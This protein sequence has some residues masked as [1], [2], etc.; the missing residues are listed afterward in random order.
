MEAAV[1]EQVGF[2]FEAWALGVGD[3]QEEQTHFLIPGFLVE[4][5]ITM[6]YGKEKQGKSWL[7]YGI[8][9]WL[10]EHERIQKVYYVDQDNPKRQLKERGIDKL[11]ETQG[12]RLK[13]LARGSTPMDG[14]ELV[15]ALAGPA[16]GTAYRGCVFIFD[17]T[18]DFVDRTDSDVQ[19]KR[20]MEQMKRM[21][22][23]GATILLVHHATKSGKTID[24]SAEF[25][26]SA[27]NVYEVKQRHSSEGSIQ[28]DLPV[29]RDRDAIKEMLLSV[30]TKTLQLSI[31]DDTFVG[32][33]SENE[34]FVLQ[35][36]K[37]LQTHP[38]GMHQSAL[39]AE[40][41]YRRDDKTHRKLLEQHIGRFWRTEQLRGKRI[42]HSI[43]GVQ[44]EP[45]DVS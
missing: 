34:Q 23:A 28:F 6:L 12:D 9:R 14:L 4:Q 31:D 1:M 20:F 29:Y 37:L 33:K 44:H 22:E 3:L 30:S 2:A 39:L 36:T 15:D 8:T 18:R 43:K 5:A 19:A 25:T 26:K 7:M 40:C 27:D 10:C 41:G 13:Y 17:S 24:G 42:Y 38:E 11:I 35:V 16:V 32:I 21:R 45:S